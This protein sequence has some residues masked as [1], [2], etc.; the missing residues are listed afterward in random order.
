MKNLLASAAIAAALAAPTLAEAASFDVYF[1][2][3]GTSAPSCNDISP[4]RYT[5]ARGAYFAC[6]KRFYAE[7]MGITANATAKP[8]ACHPDK[9]VYQGDPRVTRYLGPTRK[10]VGTTPANSRLVS[11]GC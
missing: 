2:R 1:K 6:Q 10:Y 7:G 3:S 9:I 4:Q 11:N 5:N 8:D